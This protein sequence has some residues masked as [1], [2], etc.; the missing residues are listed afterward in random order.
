MVIMTRAKNKCYFKVK[1][2]WRR[3]KNK[4]TI[5]LN[6]KKIPALKRNTSLSATVPFSYLFH[7]I[8]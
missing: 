7:L 3:K 1:E 2:S 4:L 5:K 8:M 6:E